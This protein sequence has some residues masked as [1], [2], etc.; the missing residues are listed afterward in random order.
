M[1]NVL[2][3]GEIMLRISP[4]AKGE[5]IIDA[6]DYRI[7]PGG[8]EANVAVALANLG[9][10]ASFMTAL[11]VD[12]PLAE[13]TLS[14]LRYHGVDVSR[15]VRTSGRM[16]SYWTETGV[17]PR[18]SF[19]VYDREGSAFSQ[20]TPSDLDLRRIMQGI[21]WFHIS[22][23]TPAVSRSAL[24]CLEYLLEGMESTT[25]SIDLN[26]RSK[27]W[28]W[29]G[30]DKKVGA[31]E[32]MFQLCRRAKVL[33]ANETEMAD[34]LGISMDETF[35]LFNDLELLAVSDRKSLSASENLWS[36]MI[37]DRA[38]KKH[39]GPSVHL[40]DIVD[41]VGAGDSFAAGII[42]S[43]LKGLSRQDTIDTAVAL[44]ALKHTIIGDACRF[45]ED[46]V[47]HFLATSGSGCIVR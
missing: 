12:N 40:K 13:K 35:K 42:H 19:V 46:D 45:S 32:I 44:S 36:G 39:Q 29:L 23:I 4:A 2:T 26:Y 16:G 11:P 24:D 9:D 27:L 22:G 25:F 17:G 1:K 14:Y 33:M 38:G 7:E 41:R 47:Q 34:A 20:I 37:I 10:R 5:R 15:I 43:C 31:R 8:S 30:G 21:D 6:V 28:V 18:N 3:F